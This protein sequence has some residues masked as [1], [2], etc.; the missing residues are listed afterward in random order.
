M[1][2]DTTQVQHLAKHAFP[3]QYFTAAL[4]AVSLESEA[5]AVTYINSG[6]E[7]NYRQLLKHPEYIKEWSKSSSK[8]FERLADG[9]TGRVKLTDT[10]LFLH[11]HEVPQ[12]RKI[13][14]TYGSF[15]YHVRP[16]KK[17]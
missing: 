16:N 12:N 11:Q 3:P 2:P 7:L 9:C 4:V 1:N 8:T 15:Q 17:E 14:A 5:L 10:I 13:N 6:K